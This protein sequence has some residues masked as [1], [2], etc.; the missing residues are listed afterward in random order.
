MVVS[1]KTGY[2]PTD[3]EVIY[4]NIKKVNDWLKRALG[5]EKMK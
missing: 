4:E 2:V 1:P 3:P 5:T